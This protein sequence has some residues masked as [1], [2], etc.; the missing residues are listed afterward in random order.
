MGKN[1]LS[2]FMHKSNQ[3]AESKVV[4]DAADAI[5]DYDQTV[6][7]HRERFLRDHGIPVD[8]ETASLSAAVNFDRL[9]IDQF[10]AADP[11]QTFIRDSQVLSRGE[12]IPAKDTADAGQGLDHRQRFILDCQRIGDGEDFQAIKRERSQDELR[13]FRADALRTD[14]GGRLLLED[15]EDEDRPGKIDSRAELMKKLSAMADV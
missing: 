9:A 14:N 12:K 10:D 4:T 15:I 11:Y 8:G 5:E 1:Y 7:G 2:E 3:M 13:R 6:C